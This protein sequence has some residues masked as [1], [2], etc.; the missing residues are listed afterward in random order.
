MKIAKSN[1][2]QLF[3]AE[4]GIERNFI[5]PASSHSGRLLEA[6]IKSMKRILL[7]V[8]KSAIMNFEKLTT[9]VTQIKAVLNSCPLSPLSSDPDNFNPLTPGH[10]L[11]GN[12][13][14][15]FPGPYTTLDSVSYIPGGKSFNLFKISSGIV[16]IITDYLTHLQTRAKWSVQNL[17]LRGNQRQTLGLAYGA[18]SLSV[19]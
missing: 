11:A 19:S 5:L 4:E 7:R 8:A 9:L 16:Y 1:T 6:N 12:A 3:I 14:S 10:L 17:D 13:I 2:I 18:Y 15:S